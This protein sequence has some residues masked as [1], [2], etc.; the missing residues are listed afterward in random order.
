MLSA[1]VRLSREAVKGDLKR[2]PELFGDKEFRLGMQSLLSSPEALA[3]FVRILNGADV[4]GSALESAQRMIDDTTAGSKSSARP[5]DK[6]MN[7][8]GGA[9]APV[10]IPAL[11]L[12][13]RRWTTCLSAPGQCSMN[14]TPSA[15]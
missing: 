4:K 12:H 7:S 9:S 15:R 6:F 11:E 14:L 2:L 1:F 10:I 3:R 5:G 13:R 8:L